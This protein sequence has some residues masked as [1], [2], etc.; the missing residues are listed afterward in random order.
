MA[1][2]CAA[3]YAQRA[4]ALDPTE[5]LA[6][7]SLSQVLLYSGHHEEGMA[8]ADLAV[9]L[10]PNSAFAHFCQGWARA[11]RG[12]PRDAIEPIETAMRLSPFDPFMPL[13]LHALTRG[14][15]WMG[16]YPAA[17]TTARHYAGPIAALG[18][19]GQA[20][21]AQR[22]MAEALQRFG[23]DFRV[24]MQPLGPIPMEDR[25]EDREHLLEGYRK[26][27]VLD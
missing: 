23:E 17:V 2:P 12:R 4:I 3:E 24:L 20:D 16:D 11:R 1:L 27:G 13:F 9:S 21:E 19:T 15:Y 18:Q 26:A 14:Y 6:H 8:E 10:D 5:A 25:A 22:I 7:D